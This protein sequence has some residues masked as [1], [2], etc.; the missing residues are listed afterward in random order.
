MEIV[1]F[2]PDS[3]KENAYI[4]QVA[5]L[6]EARN[7]DEVAGKDPLNTAAIYTWSVADFNK[8]RVAFSKAANLAG[9]TARKRHEENIDNEDGSK[10]LKVW[11]TLTAK[12]AKRRNKER[13]HAAKNDD[14][15]STSIVESDQPT[16]DAPSNEA[17]VVVEET[18]IEN[19]EENTGENTGE[20]SEETAAQNVESTPVVRRPRKR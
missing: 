7:A 15:D 1:T 11:F 6:I 4:G 8:E 16:P 10:S 17:D 18:P 19:V 13:E 20:N 5:E 3:I 9:Y 14:G 12:H 2:V